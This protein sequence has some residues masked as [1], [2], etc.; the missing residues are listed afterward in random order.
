MFLPCVKYS[1]YS[2]HSRPA[3]LTSWFPVL[4][5]DLSVELPLGPAAHGVDLLQ[6]AVMKEAAPDEERH[7]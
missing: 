6:A 4:T 3:V 2:A 1:R 7:R 5:G